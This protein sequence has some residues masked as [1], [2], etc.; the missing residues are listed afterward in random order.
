MLLYFPKQYMVVDGV[1]YVIFK[2]DMK[3]FTMIV[4]IIKYMRYTGRIFTIANVISYLL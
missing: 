4:S 1:P 2:P 3:F